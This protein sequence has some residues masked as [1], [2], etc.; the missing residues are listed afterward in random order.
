MLAGG[1]I[2]WA[3]FAEP[4]EKKSTQGNQ[5]N[6][7]RLAKNGYFPLGITTTLRHGPGSPCIFLRT[8]PQQLEEHPGGP[9]S[10]PPPQDERP[11]YFS[12][13][14]G[15]DGRYSAS[16]ASTGG[17]GGNSPAEPQWMKE[18]RSDIRWDPQRDRLFSRASNENMK[19]N[20]RWR[21]GPSVIMSSPHYLECSNPLP[22][23]ARE[24]WKVHS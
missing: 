22:G 1:H 16:G 5:D 21:R 15:P 2:L 9:G 14:G 12:N 19:E 7:G 8:N 3:K 10:D 20:P 13:W 6:R 4:T 17:R 23:T 18:R 11:L 24:D